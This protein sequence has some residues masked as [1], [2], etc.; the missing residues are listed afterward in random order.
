MPGVIVLQAIYQR[1]ASL[2]LGLW[3]TGGV[4]VLLGVGSF[5]GGGEGGNNINNMA[6]FAWLEESP[7][8]LSWWLWGTI[9]LIAFLALNAVLCSIETIRNKYRQAGFLA[10]LAPQA[11]H[12]GFLCIV[13]AHLFS[14]WGGSKQVLPVYEG[15][16]IGLPDGGSVQVVNIATTM[17]PRGFP[18]DFS[19][20]V[21]YPAG[22]GV[23][24]STISPN[25]PAF[26][27][28]FGIYLKEVAPPPYRAALIEIHREPGAGMALA[29]ALLF[30]VGNAAL[31]Y[32][33]R[34]R[35]LDHAGTGTS[36]EEGQDVDVNT[37]SVPGR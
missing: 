5:A 32:L 37:S 13:L 21:R 14:A 27:R 9:G 35:R 10:M 12:L 3:L 15:G 22:S 36:G 26:C 2:N 4:I 11:M 1:L 16:V 33:R 34:G 23:T 28:G 20:D 6:L 30:T 19:A 24:T 29:G 17:G 25:H 18:S 8:A 7:L 31:L